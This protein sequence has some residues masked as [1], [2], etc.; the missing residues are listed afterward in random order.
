MSPWLCQLIDHYHAELFK[1]SMLNANSYGIAP[2]KR[3]YP[4]NYFYKKMLSCGFSLQV[5]Q[6]GTSSEN[7]QDKFSW[8]NKKKISNFFC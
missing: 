5:P 2:D 1:L 8:R 4:H 3:G 7:P 6:L